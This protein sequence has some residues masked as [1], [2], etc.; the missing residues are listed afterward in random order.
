MIQKISPEEAKSIIDSVMPHYLVDVREH[1]EYEEGH[2]PGSKLVPLSILES[3]YKERIANKDIPV[4]VHCQSGIRAG[5]AAIILY[6]L[7]YKDVRDFGGINDWP[8]DIDKDI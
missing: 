7:G 8:Y 5:K 6:K 1:D 2:I 4:L 3:V